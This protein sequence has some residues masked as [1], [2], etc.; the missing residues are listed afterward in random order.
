M[1]KSLKDCFGKHAYRELGSLSVDLKD[2][3]ATL[4]GAVSAYH[5]KHIAMGSIRI[6]AGVN[7]LVNDIM[8][9]EQ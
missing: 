9:L 6:M 7:S 5:P 4:R 3:S 8:G 1:D 2:G